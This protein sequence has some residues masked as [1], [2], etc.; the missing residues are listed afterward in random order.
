MIDSHD[1]AGFL[2]LSMS[3]MCSS[4]PCL[5]AFFAEVRKSRQCSR[6]PCSGRL[7]VV[8]LEAIRYTFQMSQA[9]SVPPTPHTPLSP[10]SHHHN[11]ELMTDEDFVK[12]IEAMDVPTTGEISELLSESYPA[13]MVISRVRFLFFIRKLRKQ[14][15]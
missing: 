2:S 6:L 14:W 1:F 10:G 7:T 11:D 9:G 12:A 8:L 5:V 4:T 13:F 15:W 3:Q